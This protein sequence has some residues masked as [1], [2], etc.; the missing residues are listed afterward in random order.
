M[1]WFRKSKERGKG[2]AMVEY[3]THKT[4]DNDRWDLLALR[5][6]GDPL[7]LG[8]LLEANPRHA[9]KT[10]LEAGLRLLVPILDQTEVTPVKPE[11]VAWR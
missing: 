4:K 6:Y 11:V 3:L 7:F 2:R 10:L 9:P 5:Y 8:P 1:T